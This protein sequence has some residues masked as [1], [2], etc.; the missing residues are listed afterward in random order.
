[1]DVGT[2]GGRTADPPENAKMFPT[3]LRPAREQQ[4]FPRTLSPALALTQAQLATTPYPLT[5]WAAVSTY[6]SLINAAPQ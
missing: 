4:Q 3:P 1:M 2:I 6:R 5:Q